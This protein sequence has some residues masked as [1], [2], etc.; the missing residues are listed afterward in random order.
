MAVLQS[1][2]PTAEH[3]H[4]ETEKKTSLTIYLCTEYWWIIKFWSRAPEE[5]ITCLIW[6]QMAQACAFTYLYVHRMYVVH[7]YAM[8]YIIVILK[9]VT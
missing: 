6:N 9:T 7:V 3:I 4:S 1:R 2:R 8:T 5:H